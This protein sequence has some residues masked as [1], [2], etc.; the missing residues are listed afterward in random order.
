MK[1]LLT[2]SLISATMLS[3]LANAASLSVTC[4]YRSTDFTAVIKTGEPMKELKINALNGSGNVV[5]HG[6]IS[7][8]S[9]ETASPDVV[10]VLLLQ[11]DDQMQ[12]LSLS[13]K[14]PGVKILG[15][16]GLG[17]YSLECSLDK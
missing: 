3:N 1:L 4:N 16:R 8:I 9:T 15:T 14:N 2:L 11:D 10:S 7:A 12:A 5:T 6:S 13:E 17:H